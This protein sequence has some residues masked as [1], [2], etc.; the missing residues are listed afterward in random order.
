MPSWV[1]SPLLGQSASCLSLVCATRNI[2]FIFGE[3]RTTGEEEPFTEAV[4]EL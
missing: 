1:G 2:A 4:A 3:S